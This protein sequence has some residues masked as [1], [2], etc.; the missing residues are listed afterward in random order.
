MDK[1]ISKERMYEVVRRPII[2]EKSSLLN[3][4]NA[5]VF[6]VASDSNKYEI[7]LSVEALFS[8]NVEKVNIL[9]VKGKIKIFKGVKGKRKDF[10]KAIVKIKEGQIIDLGLGGTL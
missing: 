1:K 10:K 3:K 2:T 6:E 7:A 4:N 9:N 8:V 5:F